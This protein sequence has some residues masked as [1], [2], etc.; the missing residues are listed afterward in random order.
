MKKL[1]VLTGAGMSAESGIS[2]FRDSGGLWEQYRIEDVATPEAWESN[3]ALVH[4]FYNQR[5][6]QLKN[7]TPNAGHLGLAALEKKF[8]VKIITQNVDNL[9]ERAGSNQVLH[10]H[11]ELMK[12]RSTGPSHEVY[13]VDPD[14]TNY[15]VG[16]VC[17]KGYPLRPHIVWFGEEVPDYEKALEIVLS[18]DILV[19]IGT[20]MQVYP[21]AGLLHYVQAGIPVFLIDPNDVEV[22]RKDVSVIKA[23]ASEGIRILT[24]NLIKQLTSTK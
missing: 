18:A 24:S 14:K 11:G 9:H 2:T 1:V 12:M 16:D 7:A 10:L 15:K 20:S 4:H 6:E 19:I 22:Y 17:P 23:G 3:P 8:E 21:A 5:R 13:E